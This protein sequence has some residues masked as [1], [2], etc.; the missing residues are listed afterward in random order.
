ML[1]HSLLSFGLALTISALGVAGV[2]LP[3]CQEAAL[4]QNALTNVRTDSISVPGTP[5]GIVYASQ[6]DRAF[7]TLTGLSVNG[8]VQ[9]GNGTVGVLNT[10][11][12]SPSLIHQIPLPRSVSTIRGRFSSGSRNCTTDPESRWIPPLR[13]GR[14]GRNHSRHCTGC[15]WQSFR[16]S[17]RHPKGHDRHTEHWR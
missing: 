8:S 5:W 7:V 1:R 11:T 4:Q 13:R 9:S 14:P 16:C 15:C 2:S 10:S 3:S 17:Y 12:F 6:K